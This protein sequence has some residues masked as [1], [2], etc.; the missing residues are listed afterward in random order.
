M[1]SRDSSFSNIP[2]FVKIV[3][4]GPRDGLQNEKVWIPTEQ[5]IRFVQMLAEAGLP[6]VE[7][8]SF[9]SPRAQGACSQNLCAC[10]LRG[11]RDGSVSRRGSRGWC[12]D[13]VD[14][15]QSVLVPSGML[16]LRE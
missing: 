4:V 5:K 3:E 11:S 13:R 16:P 7:A 2:P 6:V 9:V 8:T 10:H 15:F 12:A 14:A 1:T